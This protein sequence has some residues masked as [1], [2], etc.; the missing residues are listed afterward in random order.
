MY[1]NIQTGYTRAVLNLRYSNAT[2]QTN[3]RYGTDFVR[4]MTV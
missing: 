3:G 4:P 1:I 2:G